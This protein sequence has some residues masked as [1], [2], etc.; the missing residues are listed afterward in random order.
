MRAILFEL[1]KINA[2]YEQENE[3]I[4]AAEAR[5]LLQISGSRLLAIARQYPEV[6]FRHGLYKRK[7][8]LAVGKLP[9]N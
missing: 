3:F 4:K 1:R 8:L 9:S 5:R 7:A 2:R 6:R